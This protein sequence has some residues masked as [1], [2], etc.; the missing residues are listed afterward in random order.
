[1]TVRDEQPIDRE[2]TAMTSRPRIVRAVKES[3]R[4]MANGDAGPAMAEMARDLLTGRIRLH[5][6]AATS[7]YSGPMLDGIER[8]QRWESELTPEHRQAL[9]EAALSSGEQGGD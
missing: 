3:L 8:Y 4:R 9:R 2:L 6:L 7:V 5:D 1:M